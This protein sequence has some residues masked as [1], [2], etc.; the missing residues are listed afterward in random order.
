MKEQLKLARECE[1]N[2]D[3]IDELILDQDHLLYYMINGVKITDN[4]FSTALQEY[5]DKWVIDLY[6]KY[7]W[8]KPKRKIDFIDGSFSEFVRYQL[9]FEELGKYAES[10]G[11]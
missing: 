10:I 8:D 4:M 7:Y 5:E 6:K 9:C 2:D 11:V 1:K 3:H